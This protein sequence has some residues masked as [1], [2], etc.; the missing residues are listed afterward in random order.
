MLRPR[1]LPLPCSLVVKNGSSTFSS[2]SAA[3][4]VPVS[5]T[6]KSHEPPGG[7]SKC[8]ADFDLDICRGDGDR[9]SRRHGIACVDDEVDQRQ[10]ELRLIG[11]RLPQALVQ[12]RHS[13]WTSPPRVWVKKVG[14]GVAAA[15]VSSIGFGSSFWRRAKAS[16]RRTNSL[17]C[18]AARLVM[19]RMA[20]L[21]FLEVGAAFD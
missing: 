18:S 17:P 7:K 1:P 10:L 4:P 21:I 9:S 2:T 8:V 16:S 14:N 20:L 15:R 3:I 6:A 12:A 11:E 5:E 19:P 13:I